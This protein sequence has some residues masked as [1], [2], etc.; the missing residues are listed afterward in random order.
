VLVEAGAEPEREAGEKWARDRSRGPYLRDAL[1]DA[2]AIIET[3]EIVTFCPRCMGS[4]EQSRTRLRE[5]L[6]AQGTPPVILCHISHVYA[7]GASLYFT[8][9]CAALDDPLSQWRA[10][11]I[12]ASHAIAA[13]GGRS[14]TTTASVGIISTSTSKRSTSRR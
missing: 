2:R 6:T 13:A 8:V 14:L 9:A 4:T 11:K 3:L 5:W 10:A 7:S 12:A 1:L